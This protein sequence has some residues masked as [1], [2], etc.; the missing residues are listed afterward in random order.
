MSELQA[1]FEDLRLEEYL[2]T[3]VE[4]GFDTWDCLTGITE[5]D[6]AT[7]GM[8]LGHRRRLQREIA[9]RLGHPAN[10]PLFAL[11]AATLQTRE[12]YCR[13]DSMTSLGQPPK[14]RYKRRPPRNPQGPTRPDTGYVA[15]SRLLRQDPKI[16]NLSFVEVAKL[17]GERWSCLSSDVKR[18][19]NENAATQRSVYKSKL[20]Q[21][22][23][24]E[25][26]AYRV[27]KSGLQPK[28]TAPSRTGCAQAIDNS[29][30]SFKITHYAGSVLTQAS[31]TAST[32]TTYTNNRSDI[33]PSRSGSTGAS[34]ICG[35]AEVDQ[36]VSQI[37]SIRTKIPQQASNPVVLPPQFNHGEILSTTFECS[38]FSRSSHVQTIN[39]FNFQPRGMIWPLMDSFLRS[40][41]SVYYLVNPDELWKHLN[42]ALET[43]QETPT[44]I[45]SKLCVC[46]ALGCQASATSTA[47][48]AIMWYENG[49]RYLDDR[50][51]CLDLAVMQILA[52]ISM[53][54]MAQ[55]PATSSHYLDTAIRIGEANSLHRAPEGVRQ[56]SSYW[57]VEW[58]DIWNTINTMHQILLLS[59]G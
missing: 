10:E 40:V 32:S 19:W 51:W 8:K 37:D 34:S 39:P 22:N 36:D 31:P 9:R 43:T 4:H 33:S 59:C 41:N 21:F 50:D 28:H 6:M 48:M 12:R 42:C 5:T 15:Y 46:L 2:S 55:R 53:F 29:T 1:T 16:A 44:L 23:Q 3:L 25:T 30:N 54:H 27:H 57:D 14:G 20:A 58:L 56:T 45:M 49:R 17:V 38:A 24:T 7:L 52:L 26:E 13:P 11:P 18:I 35:S 47:D